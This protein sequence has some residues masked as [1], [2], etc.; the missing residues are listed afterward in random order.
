MSWALQDGDEPG[1]HQKAQ[2]HEVSLAGR[3]PTSLQ[4]GKCLITTWKLN[5]VHDP[6]HEAGKVLSSPVLLQ[7]RN[8]WEACKNPIAQATWPTN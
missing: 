2:G 3:G 4:E 8:I 1:W 7:I 6:G 5:K